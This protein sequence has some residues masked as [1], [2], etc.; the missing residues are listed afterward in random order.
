MSA[1]THKSFHNNRE[2]DLLVGTGVSAA[3]GTRSS[4]TAT[5]YWLGY[6]T[7]QYEWHGFGE[8]GR[9]QDT[10]AL[11]RCRFSP[12]KSRRKLVTILSITYLSF[13]YAK[14]VLVRVRPPIGQEANEELAVA[15]SPTQEHVQARDSH[16]SQQSVAPLDHLLHQ[17]WQLLKQG[18]TFNAQ[19]APDR[20]MVLQVLMPERAGEK[21]QL[22]S[23]ASLKGTAK[24]YT[25]DACLD[26][27]VS[28]VSCRAASSWPS[29]SSA[30]TSFIFCNSCL[31]FYHCICRRM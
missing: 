6:I 10:G 25:L 21:P 27:T 7:R 4:A 5:N 26:G 19:Q 11:S 23:H 30:E 13:R 1:S 31:L 12:N 16:T 17:L 24:K 15:C 18:L 22:P 8:L 3:F 2:I 29:A 9:Q 28:Q 14:Q 20:L